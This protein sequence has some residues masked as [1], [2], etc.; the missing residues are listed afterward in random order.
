MARYR[1]V[2]KEFLEQPTLFGRRLD[3]RWDRRKTAAADDSH[4][5]AAYFQHVAACTAIAKAEHDGE[6]VLR[7]ADR[8]GVPADTL[9]RKLYGESP[10]RL[11]EVIAWAILYG[12]EVLPA[13]GSI[14]DLVP[15]RW[16]SDQG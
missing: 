15:H 10:A 5:G 1:Y 9:R 11:D 4:V 12:V 2:P 3:A 14:E 8:L 7:M 6:S 13:P 16:P